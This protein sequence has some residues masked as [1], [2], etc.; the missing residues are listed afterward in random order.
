MRL[1]LLF[2]MVLIGCGTSRRESTDDAGTPVDDDAFVSEIDAWAPDAYVPGRDAAPPPH[3]ASTI[4]TTGMRVIVEPSDDAAGLVSA[5]SAATTSVHVTMYLLS[6]HDVIDALLARHAAGVDV[7]VVLNQTFPDTSTS[8]AA[9]YTQLTGAGIPTHWAS[10]TFALTH[11]KC[12]IID[13]REAWIMTMNATVTSPTANRE[14]LIVD[15][16]ASDVADA[17]RIFQGDFAGTPIA[18]YDGPLVLAPLNATTRIYALLAGAAH[19]IDVEDEELSDRDTV[20]ALVNAANR[21]VTVRVIL[22]DITRTAAGATAVTNLRAAGIPVHVLSSPYVHSKA[23]VVDG[24]SAYVGS[25]NLTYASLTM[26][27]EL[28]VIT[29]VPGVVSTVA[30]TLASDFAAGTAL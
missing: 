17:E 18:S 5:I 7:R 30:S 22:S 23:I 9:V 25:E 29:A 20:T 26:N 2:S 21:G 15:D 27:R 28:G 11:E 14:F 16:V 12:V 6:S 19:T 1:V 13:A 24:T 3:D 4:P 10:S 8:N